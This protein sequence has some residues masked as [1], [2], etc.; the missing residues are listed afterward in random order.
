MEAKP[1]CHLRRGSMIFYFYFKNWIPGSVWPH[2]VKMR[3]ASSAALLTYDKDLS[4]AFA[5]V[6]V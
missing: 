5:M 2:A 3:P 4:M 6:L 1:I